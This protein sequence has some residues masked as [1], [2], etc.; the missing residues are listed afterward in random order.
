M[1]E[2][3]TFIRR[4][5]EYLDTHIK[6]YVDTFELCPTPHL[7]RYVFPSIM[8]VITATFFGKPY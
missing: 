2:D 4:I 6:A 1:L 5:S 8:A 3:E 7:P